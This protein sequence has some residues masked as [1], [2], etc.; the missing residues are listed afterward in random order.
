MT[1]G[2]VTASPSAVFKRDEAF[3]RHIDSIDPLRAYRDE[4][5]IPQRP[6]GNPVIYFAGNSLGLQPKAT[7]KLIEQELDDWAKLAVDA[8][9]RGTTP[10]YSYHEIFREVGA[11]LV[12]GLPGAGEVVMMNSL[13]VNLHL[14]MVTFYRPSKDRFKILIEEPCFPSDMYAVKSHVRTRGLDPREAILVIKPRAGEHTIRGDDLEELINREGR[15]ISLI[16]LGGVNFITGQAFDIERFTTAGH[17][18]GC[19]VGW[20][21]AHAAGNLELHLHDWNVD[22]A[23]WCS[24]KYLNSGPGAVAGCFIH[25]RHGSNIDLP[26]YAGWWGND[27]DTRFKMHLISE[28]E[29]REGA[30]GW[31]ISNPPILSMAP[32]K[33]SLDLFDRATVPALRKKSCLLTGYLGFLLDEISKTWWEIITPRSGEEHGC[34]LSI[35]VKDRPRQRLKAL[36]E[37]GIVCDFREPNVIRLAPVPMYNTFHEV[38]TFAQILSQQTT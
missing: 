19:S 32:L 2:T 13:T 3:A 24:Y 5:L 21:L 36:E 35:V 8:H 38:W 10:W 14:M 6:D 20:D 34:Q 33:V 15:R 31:Q 29:P 9:F 27:P 37:A 1:P 25:E 23:C 12:G 16:L 11:R 7:R 30:E 26:R 18:Q 28:F 17:K 22:F 4:F